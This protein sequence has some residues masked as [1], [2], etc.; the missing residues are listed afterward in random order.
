MTINF[1]IK[2]TKETSHG[3]YIIGKFVEP[4]PLFSNDQKFRLGEFEFEMWG[5]PKDG[6][7]TLEL[8]SKKVFNW[9]LE[10]QVVRL[11]VL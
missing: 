7:V 3:T 8:V 10:Q 5:M 11:D 9:V 6:F 4:M 1:E 2:E